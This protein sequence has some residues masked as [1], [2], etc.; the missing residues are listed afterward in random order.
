MPR[1]PN[2]HSVVFHGVPGDTLL[3]CGL[4]IC[5]AGLLFGLAIYRH[6]KQLPVHKSMLEVSELIYETCKTY[7]KTQ[8][9]FILI[10]ELFIACCL[11]YT[12]DAADE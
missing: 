4:V 2:L 12:S 1:L 9:K 8:I 3:M 5:V 7:L 6:L 10:L 11:L